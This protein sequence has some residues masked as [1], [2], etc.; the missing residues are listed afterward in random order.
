MSVARDGLDESHPDRHEPRTSIRINNYRSCVNT[1]VSPEDGYMVPETCRELKNR[2]NKSI[3]SGA[4]SWLSARNIV[5]IYNSIQHNG[6]VLR[7]SWD[8]LD[9]VSQKFRYQSIT[10]EKFKCTSSAWLRSKQ[11]INITS[12]THFY[13]PPRERK[14]GTI[15]LRPMRFHDMHNEHFP[16]IHYYIRNQQDAT[17]AVSFISHC[18]ITLHVSEAFCVQHQE[19]YKL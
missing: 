7:E 12:I 9:T 13:L 1:I 11:H 4:S 2:I 17:L 15:H 3:K 10:P 16:W 5:Y 18:K 19:Y 14:T 8:V 6:D